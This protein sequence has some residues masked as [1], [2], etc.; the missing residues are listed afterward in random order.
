MFFRLRYSTQRASGS[1]ARDIF[2]RG[3]HAGHPGRERPELHQGPSS[4]RGGG[5]REPSF[6]SAGAVGAG[7]K[8]QRQQPAPRPEPIHDRGRSELHQRPPPV[9][10]RRLVPTVPIERRTCAQPVGQLTF[11]GLPNFLQGMATFLYDPAPTPLSWRSFFG[12][13]Y[14][15][16]EIRVRSNLTLTLGFREESSTGWSEAQ[17]RAANYTTN[18]SGVLLCASM[19]ASNVCLPQ[20]SNNLFTDD[21][22]DFLPQPRAAIAWSPFDRKTVIR[23]GFSMLNDLQDALGYRADQ[24]APF[25]PTYTIGTAAAPVSIATLGF[26]ILPSAPPPTNPKALLLPGGVQQDLYAP[27]VLEYSLTIQREL[28]PNTSISVGYVGNHGYHEIVGADANAPAPV[29]CPAS[30]C[31]ATFPT[32]DFPLDH[33]PDLRR[34]VRTTCACGDAVRSHEHQAERQPGHDLDV[35]LRRRQPIQRDASGREPSI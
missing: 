7:R 2:S 28:S 3:A 29:V 4:R 6:Q 1:H 17:G 14:V 26:P 5:R 18:A 23:A 8:Q 20:V 19:P 32:T 34:F 24:N 25:N 11:T 10:V 33:D 13:A 16:D 22:A 9:P 30:P 21:H 35:V 27:T 31:P 15:E 12:A